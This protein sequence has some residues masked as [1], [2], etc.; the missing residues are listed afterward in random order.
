[1]QAIVIGNQ[2]FSLAVKERQEKNTGGGGYIVLRASAG[3]I[4][5]YMD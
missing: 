5:K 4:Q 1:M 2:G 3:E